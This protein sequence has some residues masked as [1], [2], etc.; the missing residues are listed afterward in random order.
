MHCL[1]LS[2]ILQI[3]LIKASILSITGLSLTYKATQT[4][5]SR[6]LLFITKTKRVV[7]FKHFRSFN[8]HSVSQNKKFITHQTYQNMLILS[9]LKKLQLK[10]IKL[11]KVAAQMDTGQRLWIT[12]N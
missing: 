8:V 9:M 12:L 3:C 5:S 6:P 1:S 2:Y 7:E 11:I 10:R 4:K